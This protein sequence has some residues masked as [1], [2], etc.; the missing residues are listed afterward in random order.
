MPP[1]VRKITWH[2]FKEV[3]PD[4]NENLGP[5]LANVIVIIHKR[6]DFSVNYDYQV[7]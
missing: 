6:F 4:L 1:R 2:S 7:Y 5:F 3:P